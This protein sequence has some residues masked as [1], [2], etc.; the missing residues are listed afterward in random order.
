[1]AGPEMTGNDWA[2]RSSTEAVKP[3]RNLDGSIPSKSWLPMAYAMLHS[4]A[5]AEGLRET[6]KELRKDGPLGESRL[7]CVHFGVFLR[8]LSR[9]PTSTIGGSCAGCVGSEG[10]SDRI[11]RAHRDRRSHQGRQPL[12]TRNE[13]DPLRR[14]TDKETDF[15]E[16]ASSRL[17]KIRQLISGRKLS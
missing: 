15:P 6:M 5:M 11:L 10:F 1:M 3:Y 2:P 16:R 9:V 14:T 7:R 12:P 8:I 13:C 4:K 17:V